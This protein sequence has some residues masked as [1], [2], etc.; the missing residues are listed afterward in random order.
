MFDLQRFAT[1]FLR[2][3]LREIIQSDFRGAAALLAHGPVPTR[4]QSLSDAYRLR[5]LVLADIPE[6]GPEIIGRAETLSWF[7]K[8][9][10]SGDEY[11]RGYCQYAA[12]GIR[13]DISERERWA[14]ELGRLSV[15]PVYRSALR[16]TE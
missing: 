12:A 15:K 2:A 8:P 16:V 1:R 9:Q 3:R 6:R 14:Q 5:M 4:Y 13:G 7:Q 10:S 11:A